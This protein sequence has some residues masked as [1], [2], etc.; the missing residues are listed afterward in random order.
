MTYNVHGFR[1][2]DRKISVDRVA[3]VIR[4]CDPD[5]V[6]LQEVDV[7]RHRS[8]RVDQAQHLADMLKMEFH[9][10]PAMRLGDELYGL[11]ML[12]RLPMRMVKSGPLPHVVP[13]EPRAVQWADVEIAG[14]SVQI[15]NTHLG[16]RNGERAAQIDA[17]LGPEWLDHEDF[18]DPAIVLGDFNT[19]PTSRLFQRIA[20]RMRMARHVSPIPVRRGTFLGVLAIDHIFISPEFHVEHVEVPAN[21]R[22]R[23]ASDHLPLVADL[24]FP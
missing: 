17:L 10:Y 15:I 22:A 14:N 20:N 21:L 11:A 13:F 9:F 23:L 12:S 18:A 1:G 7:N 2:V 24:R 19:P 3:R 4:D 5:L 16:L 8:G 6:A